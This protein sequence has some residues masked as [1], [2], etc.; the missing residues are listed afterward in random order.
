MWF[1]LKRGFCSTILPEKVIA[2]YEKLRRGLRDSVEAREVLLTQEVTLH[3]TPFVCNN[4][5]QSS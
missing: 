1:L 3:A 4:L 5:F 2:E